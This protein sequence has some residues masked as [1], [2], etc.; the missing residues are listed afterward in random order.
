MPTVPYR[1]WSLQAAG[2]RP[3]D[4]SEAQ[5]LLDALRAGEKNLQVWRFGKQK[6]KERRS[7]VEKDW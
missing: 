2:S 7:D 1:V 5:R 4:R 3:M 6:A